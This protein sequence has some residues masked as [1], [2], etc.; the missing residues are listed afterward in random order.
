MP[1][2]DGVYE[3]WREH[4]SANYMEGERVRHNGR[5]F[6]CR[7]DHYPAPLT[8]PAVGAFWTEF[9]DLIEDIK[10]PEVETSTKLF[11]APKPVLAGGKLEQID[12]DQ[13]AKLVESG[14]CNVKFE[15]KYP[16]CK[17]IRIA[18]MELIDIEETPLGTVAHFLV[19]RDLT[20]EEE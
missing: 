18:Q 1:E 6:V 19:L 17:P 20:D 10:L 14:E 16:E 13:L 12:I 4:N 3:A 2:N 9:W 5:K 15:L 7:S 8:E 11:F